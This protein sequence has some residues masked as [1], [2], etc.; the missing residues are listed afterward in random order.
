MP[1]SQ[2]RSVL[3]WI[4]S[5]ASLA[6]FLVVF[7]G[8]VRLTRSGLSI[9][10]WNPVSG[11]LPPLTQQAWQA[12][13]AKY[14]LTP[15]YRQINTGMSLDQFKEIFII[16]WIHRILARA[17]GLVFAIPFLVFVLNR[18]IP[19]REMGMYLFMGVLFLAQA[20]M[21]WEMVSSGLVEEPAVSQYLLTAHLFLALALIGLAVWTALG[22]F[23]G[24]PDYSRRARWSR[25]SKAA[26]L[27]L[28]L[29]LVQMAYGGLAAGLKAGHVSE[30]WPL[31]LG[32]LIPR[33][34]LSQIE[35]PLLNLVDAPL[36]V[37]FIHRWLA[38]GVVLATLLLIPLTPRSQVT[39][40]V[41]LGLRLILSLVVVQVGLGIAV[42]LFDVQIALALLHQLNAVALFGSFVFLLHR[43]RASDRAKAEQ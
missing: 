37:A 1:Q 13:F 2:N 4:L 29:L 12:E 32:R 35:P 18:S 26:L 10:E 30:T 8:F 17:A 39:A 19:P 11:T 23:Y 28:I 3:V 9:V 36:T 31:M 38:F 20:V 41:A 27:C 16:E 15:E 6:V 5:F 21:G 40:D 7:G 24:F 22:H 25:A 14:R 43:L 42:V 33:G 34:L